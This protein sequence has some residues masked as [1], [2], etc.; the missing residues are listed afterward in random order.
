KDPNRCDQ[1]QPLLDTAFEFQPNHWQSYWV[2]ANCSYANGGL[3]KAD[4][5]YRLA[6]Q[7][8]PVPNADLLFS[9]GVVNEKLGRYHDALEIFQRA[10]AINRADREIQQHVAFLQNS[11]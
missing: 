3:D 6:A 1:V 10:A 5:L 2:L 7:Y 9:W 4:N 11:K 8:A